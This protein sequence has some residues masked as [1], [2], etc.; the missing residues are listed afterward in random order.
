MIEEFLRLVGRTAVRDVVTKLVVFLTGFSAFSEEPLN[1]FLRGPSS[2]GKTYVAMQTLKFFP[3]RSVMLL[4]GL[5][6][7][8]L[9]HDYGDLIDGRTGAKIDLSANCL[10]YTSPSP[11]D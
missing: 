7:T 2:I 8:A 4:G 1:L 11:R 6:P 3:Q 9:V 10:L 5:S